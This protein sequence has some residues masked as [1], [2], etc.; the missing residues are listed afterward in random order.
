MK[1]GDYFVWQGK[2]N[3][4]QCYRPDFEEPF[5]AQ[6][7]QW[8]TNMANIRIKELDCLT[9]LQEAEKSLAKEEEDA[10]FWLQPTTK[11]LMLKIVRKVMITDKAEAVVAKEG[12]GCK[13]MFDNLK[14][15]QL[16]LMYKILEKGDDCLRLM[17]SN[18]NP[19]LEARGHAIV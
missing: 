2:K 13:W 8:F 5:L 3:L 14:W 16:S 10:D 19:Y 15:D 7:Q 12:S 6:T 18:M 4:D 9:Y 11:P 17:I 1:A